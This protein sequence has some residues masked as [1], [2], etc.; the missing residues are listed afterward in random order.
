VRRYHRQRRTLAA[1]AALKQLPETF[2]GS[3]GVEDISHYGV[4]ALRI[5]YR[6]ENGRQ[7]AVRIRT[8][9]EKSHA[10]DDRFCWN[11]GSKPL[12]YGL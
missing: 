8:A 5:P 6:D 4:P 3:L 2:L 10:N 12:L 9:L 7:V 1:Y 11:L